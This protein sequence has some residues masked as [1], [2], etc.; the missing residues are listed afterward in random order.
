MARYSYIKKKRA[1][2]VDQ[3]DPRFNKLVKTTTIIPKVITKTTDNIIIASSTDRLDN[4]AFRF[5]N[6][7]TLWWIIATANNLS[8]D[9]FFITPG[10]QLIIPKDVS[11]ILSKMDTINNIKPE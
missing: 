6:D 7:R 11:A 2:N 10:T 4:L 1:T 3:V 8:G 5:Y 9:S